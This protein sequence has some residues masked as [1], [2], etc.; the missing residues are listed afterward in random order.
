MKDKEQIELVRIFNTVSSFN[1]FEI[2]KHHQD[3]SRF[4]VLYSRNGISKIK[5]GLYAI[6]I[7]EYKSIKTNRFI[8]L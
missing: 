4:N 5:D 7:D 8:A 2:Q 1:S 3:K 6:N